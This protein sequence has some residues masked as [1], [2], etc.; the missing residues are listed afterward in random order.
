LLIAPFSHYPGRN[1]EDKDKQIA[2]FEKSQELQKSTSIFLQVDDT[3]HEQAH[4][5][6]VLSIPWESA[7]V[8]RGRI[9]R[10]AVELDAEG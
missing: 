5:R 1:V 3:P 7:N 10:N 2:S 9:Q 4:V 6:E 8:A